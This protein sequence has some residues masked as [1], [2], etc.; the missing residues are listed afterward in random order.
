MWNME[1][2]I[3]EPTDPS[4]G[5][6]WFNGNEKFFWS[7]DDWMPLFGFGP[8]NL[9][10]GLD[11]QQE[12][13]LAKQLTD[14]IENRQPTNVTLEVA[15]NSV[16]LNTLR[17][18]YRNPDVGTKFIDATTGF[19]YAC[20][21]AGWFNIYEIDAILGEERLNR[22]DE[23][24]ELGKKIREQHEKEE[25]E[26]FKLAHVE[27]IGTFDTVAS[28]PAD[29][30]MFMET[31]PDVMLTLDPGP[32]TIQLFG[33][34]NQMLVSI[35]MD[36]GEIEYGEDYTPDEAAQVFWNALGHYHPNQNLPEKFD[37]KEHGIP[38]TGTGKLYSRNEWAYKEAMSI[39]GPYN[40]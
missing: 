10:T 37:I 27:T 15:L 1:S 21:G 7:G 39:L 11:S 28:D 33:S 29:C 19:T 18:F 5:D 36:T 40:G 16:I 12:E 14:V 26:S 3:D 8:A 13:Y 31:N 32:N 4:V 9:E 20:D 17:Q 30:I 35:E 23:G 25:L 2:I 38:V 24:K 6:T 34:N 22:I